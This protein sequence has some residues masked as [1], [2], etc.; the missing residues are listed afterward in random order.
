MARPTTTDDET[1]GTETVP[2]P[3][4]DVAETL[5]KAGIYYI[6]GA[7]AEGSLKE[8]HQDLLLK[9]YLGPKRFNQP[10]QLMISSVGGDADEMWS[11]IDLLSNLRFQVATVGF[12]T[13]GSAGSM[14]L[15]AGTKGL[16]TIT[17]NSSVM[18]HCYGWSSSGNHHELLAHRKAEDNEFEKDIAFWTKNSK[19]KTRKDVQKYLLLKQDNWLTPKEAIEHGIA[20]R[21]GGI[22][23]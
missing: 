20:D 21:L 15:A 12:G 16:R 3:D 14:L 18:V 22:L 9:H 5:K 13:C 23:T 1:P 4:L 17:P 10:V 19:Y 7:I 11:L 2:T 8:I 6:W